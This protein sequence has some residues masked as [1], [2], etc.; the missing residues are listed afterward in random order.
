MIHYGG[1]VSVRENAQVQ[2]RQ[3]RSLNIHILTQLF[4]FSKEDIIK[5]NHFEVVLFPPGPVEAWK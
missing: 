3:F 5:N 4:F 2:G 1:R